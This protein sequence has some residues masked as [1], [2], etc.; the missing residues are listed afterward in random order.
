MT[1]KHLRILILEDLPT[2]A[3][4]MERELKRGGIE[5]DSVRVE[6]EDDFLAALDE[7]RPELILSDFRLPTFDGLS[8]LRIAKARVPL[9]PFIVVTGSMNEET[10]V[11]C[12]K[13]GAF[14]YVLKE[15]IDP[16]V[17]AVIGA[18][19]RGRILKDKLRVEEELRKLSRAV[20][21]SPA[22]II[23]TDIEGL[24]EYVNPKFTASVRLPA[25]R[26]A[27]KEPAHPQVRHDTGGGV[28]TPVGDDHRRG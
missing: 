10:A 14:D 19:E 11:E 2:D 23:V 27:R 26:G 7:F 4:L 24:I 16:T 12:M 22:S 21:Q 9:I 17:P 28:P 15:H 18:L 20:E 5:F 3:E 6:T 25:D 1:P 8:A 13:A